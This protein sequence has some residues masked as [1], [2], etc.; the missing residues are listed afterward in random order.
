M[1]TKRSPE[2]LKT[3]P[4]RQVCI[5]RW[6]IDGVAFDGEPVHFRNVYR[7]ATEASEHAEW[8]VVDVVV[9]DD[10]LPDLDTAGYLHRLGQLAP[11]ARLIVACETLD[12]STATLWLM[13]GAA[14]CVAKSAPPAEVSRACLQ[15]VEFGVC[16][17]PS[18]LHGVFDTAERL[19]LAS[20]FAP[21]LTPREMDTL[22]GLLLGQENKDIAARLGIG[23]ST[24]KTHV[25]ELLRKFGV[26]SRTDLIAKCARA[27]ASPGIGSPFGPRISRPS[28]GG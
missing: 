28:S 11:H 24:V 22:V 14:G 7:T 9:I 6:D 13:A 8:P 1:K 21:H 26:A 15:A 2:R 5:G 3:S 12:E 27:V 23:L 18:L 25:H 16:L 20:G 10:H 17:P 19:H 4:I